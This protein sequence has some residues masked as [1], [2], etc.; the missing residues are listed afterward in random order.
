M[1]YIYIVDLIMNVDERLMGVEFLICF[2][3]NDG[4]FCYFDFVILFWD[5]DRKWFFL[6]E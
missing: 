6:Y 3:F 4:C 2:I 5:L 1:E